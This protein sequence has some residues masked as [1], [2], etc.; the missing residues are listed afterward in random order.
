MKWINNVIWFAVGGIVCLA[1][2]LAI[3]FS[4]STRVIEERPVVSTVILSPEVPMQVTFCDNTLDL[5]RYN[6]YEGLDRELSSFTYFHSTVMLLFKRANR[7]FPVIEPILKA[8]GIPD[9]FKYLAVIESHLD[10]NAV[11]P[12]RAV[13][14]WQFL[15]STAR[16][17]G[18]TVTPTVD[19]RCHVQRSTEAACRYLK[20]AYAKYGNWVTV[21]VSYN[22]GMG[23][24]SSEMDR[25]QVVSALDLWL[26]EESSRYVYRMLAVKQIFE[27]PSKYGFV[28]TAKNL[29][30]PLVYKEV[31]VSNDIP[32]LV[33]YA[34]EQGVTYADLKRFNP[35]LKDTKLNVAGKSFVLHIPHRESVSYETP[36]RT[37]HDERW[38]VQ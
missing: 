9:D 28:L 36:N 33:A 25:Q 15:E 14:M 21:A 12:A 1:L 29:Y 19:E 10:P 11:S 34:K 26:V 20:D 31:T 16:E 18:L 13:G 23:R 4:D 27:H 17:C 38:T 8:N 32:D 3:G 7:Y 5:K 6:V 37:V 24:I 22:A 2:C 35:W 30:K